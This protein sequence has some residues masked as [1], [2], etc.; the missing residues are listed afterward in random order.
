ML[1]VWLVSAKPISAFAD[2][3]IVVGAPI[4]VY[5]TLSGETKPVNVFP[6]R[7]SLTQ[8][9]AVP[10]I[11]APD[12]VAC[13]ELKLRYTNCKPLACDNE[14]K[15]FLAFPPVFSRIITPTLAHGSVFSNETTCATIWPSPTSGW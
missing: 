2:I 6:A 12:V 3:A 1:V 15:T 10:V 11:V 5:V 9:G 13:P 4:A 14:M 8:Y 7:T